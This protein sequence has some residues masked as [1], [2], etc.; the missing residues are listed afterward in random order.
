MTRTTCFKLQTSQVNRN[1]GE[2]Q[3]YI[4]HWCVSW[5]SIYSQGVRRP[6]NKNATNSPW[7]FLVDSF[8]RMHGLWARQNLKGAISS[9][10]SCH[11]ILGLMCYSPTWHT[12]QQT[13]DKNPCGR[14]PTRKRI[15]WLRQ[16]RIP[17]GPQQQANAST[18]LLNASHRHSCPVDPRSVYRRTDLYSS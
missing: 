9:Q 1:F 17:S 5:S 8:C 16:S 6:K 4:S 15:R 2:I 3:V 14:W 7:I 13:G 10:I 11:V 18:G 12:K